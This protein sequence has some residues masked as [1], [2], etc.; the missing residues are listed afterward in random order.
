MGLW[1]Q[2]MIQRS[3]DDSLTFTLRS[4]RDGISTH[5][6]RMTGF[7]HSIIRQLIRITRR[8]A[9][10]RALFIPHS[11]AAGWQR[12]ALIAPDRGT[13]GI[14]REGSRHRIGDECTSNAHACRSDWACAGRQ[15]PVDARL[16]RATGDS[17][18]VGGAFPSS[19]QASTV[20][21]II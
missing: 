14:G 20:S 11:H 7:V 2:C 13:V 4:D 10:A 12:S 21:A 1:R 16:T 17:V 15:G 8:S 18:S 6:V 9:Q 3:P 19:S 5:A